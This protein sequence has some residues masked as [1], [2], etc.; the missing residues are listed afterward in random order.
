[1]HRIRLTL[2]ALMLA[3]GVAHAGIEKAGTTTANFLS[4]GTGASV[5]SMGG[6]SLGTGGSLQ[7]SA[8][9]PAALGQARGLAV[10]GLARGTRDAELPGLARRRRPHPSQ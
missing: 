1:M 5:L 7:A 4:L 8:W 3:A 9:N 6:A 10:L 2:C